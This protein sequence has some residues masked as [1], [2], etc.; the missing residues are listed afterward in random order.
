MAADLGNR[1]EQRWTTTGVSVI[2]PEQGLQVLGQLLNQSSTQIGVLQVDWSKFFRQ[3]PANHQ[4]LL[5]SQLLEE[6]HSQPLAQLPAT[7]VEHQLLEQLQAALPTERQTILVNYLQNAVATVMRTDSLPEIEVGF[8]EMGMD[9]LMTIELKNRL[10]TSLEIT[11]ASTLTYDYST[12]QAL[13]DYLLNKVVPVEASSESEA[14]FDD[15][16]N[17]LA[18]IEQLSANE[19]AALVDREL[20]ALERGI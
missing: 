17:I 14:E 11:L 13:A 5:F 20:A 19:L 10:Q 12:I 3:F 2:T 7:E 4:P 9:S 6:L 18:E 8:F 1:G 16:T 15:T